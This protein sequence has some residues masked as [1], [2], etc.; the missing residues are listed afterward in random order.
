MEDR[1]WTM[2]AEF[3]GDYQPNLT[4]AANDRIKMA[5]P[6]AGAVIIGGVPMR[7]RDGSHFDASYLKPW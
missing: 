7:S 4:L 3:F 2:R 6:S 1:L 5:G